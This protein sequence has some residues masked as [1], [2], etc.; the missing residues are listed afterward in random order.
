MGIKLE[1]I[2]TGEVIELD[3]PAQIAA[4]INSSDLGLNASKGQD[5]GW[6]LA[7]VVV[8]EIDDIR[9]DVQTMQLI[10]RE[11]GMMIQDITTYHIVDHIIDQQ[12]ALKAMAE[13]AINNNPAHKESYD[14]RVR[15]TREAKAKPAEEAKKPIVAAVKST[16]KK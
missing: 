4:I 15:A 9:K 10:A 1:R 13:D 2:T 8:G 14:A 6:R 16:D 7:P 12:N 3:R 11:K 5:Y